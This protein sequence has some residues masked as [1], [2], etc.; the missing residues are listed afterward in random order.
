MKK[1][2]LEILANV[3]LI[4]G[5]INLGILGLFKRNLIS[6]LFSFIPFLVELIYVLIGIAAVYVMIKLIRL[7]LIHI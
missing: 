4:A 6:Q 7:S 3:F 5:G 2:T 1:K